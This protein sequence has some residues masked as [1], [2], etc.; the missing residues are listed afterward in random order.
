[1]NDLRTGFNQPS[2]DSGV[3][4]EMGV[5]CRYSLVQPAFTQW[6]AIG[7][8]LFDSEQTPA[9][10]VATAGSGIEALDSLRRRISV[11]AL[12]RHLRV[13]SLVAA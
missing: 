1:M 9:M 3:I 6:V 12:E 10:L 2:V 11:R 13:E 4:E 5:I 8:L 7:M